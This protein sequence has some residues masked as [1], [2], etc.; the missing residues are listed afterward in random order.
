MTEL[1]WCKV[2]KCWK[3]SASS[4]IKD[5]TVGF[6]LTKP[7]INEKGECEVKLIRESSRSENK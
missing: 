2:L 7:R 6:C 5:A 1:V 3:N 4:A